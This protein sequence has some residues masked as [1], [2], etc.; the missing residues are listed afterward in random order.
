MKKYRLIYADPPWEYGNEVSN[1]AAKNHYSTMKLEDLKRLPV[2]DLTDDD[3]LLAMWYTGNHS[4][5]A[6]ELAE[7]WGF[8]VKQMFLFTWV[9]LTE[10]AERTINA[11][12]SKQEVVDY[13]DWLD[14]LDTVTRMNGGNYSRQ[15]QESVLIAR[16]GKGLERQSA[17][18]KQIIYSPLSEHSAKP[19]EAR[20]R[21]NVLYGDVPRIELFARAQDDGWDSWGNQ[22]D[23]SVDLLP[24]VA[25]KNVAEKAA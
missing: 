2:W 16:R 20:H 10:K 6:R 24:G 19:G 1:G 5:E 4:Q 15:N 3:A 17:S 22:C 12:L 13:Y 9:K 21:L 18:V 8:K 14:L 7:A 23:R 25:V 11:A